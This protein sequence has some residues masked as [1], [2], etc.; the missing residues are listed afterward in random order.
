MQADQGVTPLLS[1]LSSTYRI[2]FMAYES[3]S[4]SQLPRAGRVRKVL[5]RHRQWADQ[6]QSGVFSGVPSF[7]GAWCHTASQGGR[8]GYESAGYSFAQHI[9]KL[10]PYATEEDE[11]L[12]MLSDLIELLYDKKHRA[13]VDW[14]ARRMPRCIS[15]V[16]PRRRAAFFEGIRKCHEHEGLW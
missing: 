12:D 3:H 13:T 10:A 9:A 14:F 6:L 16:P 2:T 4:T 8:N 5:A 7:L 11:W 15:L 1:L